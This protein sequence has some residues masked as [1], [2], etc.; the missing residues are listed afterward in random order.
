[1]GAVWARAAEAVTEGDMAAE[2]ARDQAEGAGGNKR[3]GKIFSYG[4]SVVKKSKGGNALRSLPFLHVLLTCT[5]KVI[6]V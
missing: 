2:G 1:M 5:R 6:Y 4:A 3:Y